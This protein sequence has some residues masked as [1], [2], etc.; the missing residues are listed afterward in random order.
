MVYTELDTIC[1]RTPGPEKAG[2]G[3]EA[4]IYQR[5]SESPGEKELRMELGD[6]A[7]LA[8]DHLLSPS[9]F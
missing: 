2:E 4:S 3:Q 9:P 8:E 5:G 7:E 6:S 1:S